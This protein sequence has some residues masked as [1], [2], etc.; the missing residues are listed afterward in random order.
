MDFAK[1]YLGRVKK[2]AATTEQEFRQHPA[3]RLLGVLA[4]ILEGEILRTEKDLPAAIVV[5]ERAVQLDDEMEYDEPEP[6]PFPARHWLG[7]ALVEAGRFGDAEQ[8]YR[9]DLDEHPHNGWSLLGLKQALK[10]QGK[11]DAAVDKD[12]GEELGQG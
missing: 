5:L 10:G 11:T 2:T 12:L 9:A 8:V 3:K 4:G 7:A 1:L 6:L